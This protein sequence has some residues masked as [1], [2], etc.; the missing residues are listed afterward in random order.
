MKI[1]FYGSNFEYLGLAEYAVSYV[2]TQ[3]FYSGSELK[4][5]LPFT[6]KMSRLAAAENIIDIP[7]KFSGMITSFEDTLEKGIITVNALSFD[8][9]L[10]RRILSEGSSGDTLMTLLDKNAGEASNVRHRRFQNTYFDKTVDCPGYFGGNVKFRPVSYCVSYAGRR[11]GFGLN[12]EILQDKFTRRI[13]IYGR[14]AL[15]RSVS[16]NDRKQVVLTDKYDKFYGGKY[17][18]S[19]VGRI[20]GTVFHSESEYDKKNLV[21]IAEY[22]GYF[23]GYGGQGY[24]L[25]EI[26]SK[27]EPYTT[28]EE[29]LEGQTI[30]LWT[31]L[32]NYLT[33]AAAEELSYSL[34][35]DAHDEMEIL[36]TSD[37]MDGVFEVGDIITV[38]SELF[39]IEE[40]MRVTEMCE[41]FYDKKEIKVT[42]GHIYDYYE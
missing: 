37:K 9:F 39:G 14:Y 28:Y 5:V 26:Y 7:G 8:G 42:L 41:S 29:R 33:S 3:R 25:K 20:N 30:Y 17:S 22:T 19:D 6:E 16:Q 4:L 40:S 32:D 35:T 15:D 13:R 36:L 11:S 10:S 18:Y 2:L 23:S 31:V 34:Y 21:D 38:K 24:N 12:A 1:Y 27:I